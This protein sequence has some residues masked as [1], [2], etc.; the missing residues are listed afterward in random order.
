M[1]AI[2]ATGALVYALASAGA[3][4]SAFSFPQAMLFAALISS[5]DPVATLSILKRV[6]AQVGPSSDRDHTAIRPSSDRH[7]RSSSY[8]R[9]CTI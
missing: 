2:I 5:T 3:I 6:K 7:Q 4:A 1:L 9:S 8:S